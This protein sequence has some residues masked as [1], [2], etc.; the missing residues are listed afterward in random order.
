MKRTLVRPF[1]K[2]AGGKSKLL[3]EILPALP[4]RIATYYETFL[5]GGAVFFAL[6]SEDRPRFAS[7]VLGDANPELINTYVCVRDY[8]EALLAQL[9]YAATHATDREYFFALR[10]AKPRE[11]TRVERAARFIFL[12]RTCFCGLYRENLAGEFNVGPGTFSRPRIFNAR[13]LAAVARAL[14]GVELVVSDFARLARHAKAGDAIYFDPPY[15]PLSRTA[16]FHSYT[17]RGF[18]ASDHKRLARIYR[19]C[20]ERGAC[21]VLSNSSAPF[22]QRLYSDLDVRT[23]LAPRRINSIA[24]NRGPV[25]EILVCGLAS[26]S[27]TGDASEVENAA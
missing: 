2:W 15:V 6:A 9:R 16:N 23:V 8:L 18:A 4:V 25:A 12:N 26:P 17:A 1:L 19:R 24:A 7:A 22:A 3:G 20:L 14:Q 10:A 27:S 5:G 13:R 21:A 11:L